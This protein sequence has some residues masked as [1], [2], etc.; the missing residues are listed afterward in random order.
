MPEYACVCVCEEIKCMCEAVFLTDI[1][2]AEKR[3][4]T[5]KKQAKRLH[6]NNKNANGK[7]EWQCEIKA[8]KRGE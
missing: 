4:V 6:N 1:K 5:K 2:V 7:I 3:K 8:S